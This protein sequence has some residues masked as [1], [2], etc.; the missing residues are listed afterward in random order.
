M[1]GMCRILL[2]CR[3]NFSTIRNF[4]G[5]PEEK[6]STTGR[7]FFWGGPAWSRSLCSVIQWTNVCIITGGIVSSGERSPSCQSREPSSGI[8]FMVASVLV[9]AFLGIL[10]WPVMIFDWTRGHLVLN[11]SA[12]LLQTL[13]SRQFV[14][15]DHK[16]IALS[17]MVYLLWNSGGYLQPYLI[18]GKV[19]STCQSCSAVAWQE[20]FFTQLSRYCRLFLLGG[21]G[22]IDVQLLIPREQKW[23]REWHW[24]KNVCKLVWGFCLHVWQE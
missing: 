14:H 23:K 16:V 20:Y 3:Q 18:E 4:D 5:L 24:L 10:T 21:F 22:R 8:E 7:L 12:R 9:P 1:I 11:S 6:L 19:S 17:N 2:D 15:V 13:S